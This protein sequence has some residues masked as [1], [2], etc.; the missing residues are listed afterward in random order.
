MGLLML[1]MSA[2]AIA[3]LFVRANA[4]LARYTAHIPPLGGLQRILDADISPRGS[5]FYFAFEHHDS[6]DIMLLR[7]STPWPHSN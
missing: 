5:N 4:A 1:E 3:V 6:N 7:P 2:R